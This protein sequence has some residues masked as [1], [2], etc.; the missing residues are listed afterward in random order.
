MWKGLMLLAPLFPLWPLLQ[1]KGIASYLIKSL[2][3]IDHVR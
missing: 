1:L 2:L 3:E